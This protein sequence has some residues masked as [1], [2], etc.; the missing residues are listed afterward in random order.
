MIG[1]LVTNKHTFLWLLTQSENRG[2][3]TY[4]SCLVAADTEE[5]AK[6]IMPGEYE[7]FKTRRWARSSDGVH[8]EK[9]GV[10]KEDRKGK[11]IIA[12]FNAG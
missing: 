7:T 10:T 8:A 12:S 5:E 11:V 4:D 6:L 2:Y 9:I 3:D 1:N